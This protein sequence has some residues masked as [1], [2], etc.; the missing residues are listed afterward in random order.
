MWRGQT[1]HCRVW[2]YFNYASN[3]E[4]DLSK[5]ILYASGNLLSVVTESELK[6]WKILNN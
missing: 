2:P 6:L 4:A 3:P 5:S 1:L